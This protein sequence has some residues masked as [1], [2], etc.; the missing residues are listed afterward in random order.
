VHSKALH[1]FG[2][3]TTFRWHHMPKCILYSVN[4]M[5]DLVAGD[6]AFPSPFPASAL[7][8]R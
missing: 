1:V 3:C 2:P 5:V 7:I 8:S 6:G 4:G